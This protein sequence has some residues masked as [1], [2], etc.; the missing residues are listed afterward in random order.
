MELLLDFSGRTQR[1][2]R[3]LFLGLP[4]VGVAI[5]LIAVTIYSDRN[6]TKTEL[7]YWRQIGTQIRNANYAEGKLLVQRAISGG[8]VDQQEA[9][10]ALA[11]IYRASG[12][13]AQAD[14][15]LVGLAPEDAVGYPPAH[16]LRAIIASEQFR[17]SGDPR[18]IDRLHWHLEHADQEKS[19]EMYRARGLY[20]AS[21]GEIDRAVDTL[22]QAVA[23]RPEV[24]F[25]IAELLVQHGRREEA[26]K[27]VRK[28]EQ[29][30]R[31]RFDQ[32]TDDD[33][34][35]LRLATA[36]FAQGRL[37]EAES[38]V[39]ERLRQ[40]DD[41]KYRQLLSM[42]LVNFYDYQMQSGVPLSESLSILQKSVDA[43]PKNPEALRR[44][45]ALA[46]REGES[47]QEVRELL[48][49]AIA[50]GGASA[51]GHFVLGVVEWLAEDRESAKFHLEQA[52]E[53]SPQWSVVANNLAYLLAT[54]QDAD[55]SRAEELASIAVQGDANNFEYWDTRGIIR[56]KQGK[57]RGAATDYQRALDLAPEDKR[58]LFRNRLAK[59]YRELGQ[60][61]LANAFASDGQEQDEPEKE[62][63]VD[64]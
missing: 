17:Q 58:E 35:R 1:R 2:V 5:A 6:R 27:V 15:V 30:Y 57:L 63:P 46:S 51:M 50:E 22:M 61:E 56:Q 25:E 40:G 23:E 8:V 24:Y 38:L 55:L 18:Q 60:P 47:L 13:E 20:Y 48:I 49:G 52:L 28:A 10:F 29:V 54:D 43:D 64:P 16:R 12:A 26:A 4:A 36:L 9:M 39:R 21:K 62:A 59:I 34:L 41:Q 19:A 37:P 53:L 42:I 33:D 11:Q 32:N 3:D 7:G 45:M 44:L 14:R 31:R